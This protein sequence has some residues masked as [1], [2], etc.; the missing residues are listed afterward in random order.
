MKPTPVKKPN[1]FVEM[2]KEVTVTSKEFKKFNLT[3]M[4]MLSNKI[5]GSKPKNYLWIVFFVKKFVEILK[6]RTVGSKLKKLQSY[7]QNIFC[8]L[9]YF[10]A[11][12]SK[13]NKYKL[14][15]PFY[16]LYVYFV[17]IFSY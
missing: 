8:D 9:T 14:N 5:I 12:E 17:S 6:S 1:A 7:H 15:N 16:K 11:E 13:L 4:N 2:T 10:G 3:K